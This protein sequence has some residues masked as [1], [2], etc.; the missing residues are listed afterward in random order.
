[1]SQDQDYRP[2][3]ST[4]MGM[5]FSDEDSSGFMLLPE[6]DVEFVEAVTRYEILGELARGGV[7][8]VYRAR[9]RD[10]GR[11]VAI[12]VLLKKHMGNP[13]HVQRFIN[14]S[15]IMGF[16]QHPHITQVYEFGNCRDGRPFYSMLLVDGVTLADMLRTRKQQSIQLSVLL[17]IFAGVCEAMDYTHSQG[18]VHLDLKPRNIMVG[19][20][21]EVHVMDWGLAKT[22]RR[23]V[24]Q[25]IDFYSEDEL[26]GA[27]I[28]NLD[29]EEQNSVCG[30]LAYMSPEMARGEKVGKAS[31]IFGLG[32]ILCE[33]LTGQ[34]PIVG[35]NK[36]EMF[37][38]AAAGEIG[39]VLEK[40]D[41]A[42]GD[43]TLIRLAKRC[44]ALRPGDRPQ[45]VRELVADLNHYSESALSRIEND[46]TR[47]FELSLDLF[48]IAGL[49][50]YFRR[51]NSNFS[52]VLGFSDEELLSKP[53]IEFVHPEDQAKTRQVM[54]KLR[55]GQ[56]IARFRNRY[57]SANGEFFEF[58]WAAKA[59]PNENIVFA[60]ARNVT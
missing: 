48:C 23:E 38:V 36:Q 11:I 52:R 17:R 22:L 8:A 31:D 60:V 24:S 2:D 51:I 50:G 59:I 55:Q 30:T 1:M 27:G 34:P 33:I 6:F 56:P 9:D 4:V 14:E 47:F 43:G 13:V 46:M 19:S 26:F 29:N 41:E 57:Q 44:L 54:S 35:K 49:D 53:F 37:R 42:E 18:V 16:L 21:G 25:S 28:L 58:E 40:L 7:G 45:S 20:F 15:R 12:K 32:A 5:G 10:L 39:G 3:D